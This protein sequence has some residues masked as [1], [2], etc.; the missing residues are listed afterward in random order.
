MGIRG[1]GPDAWL[2]RWR[3]GDCPVHGVGCVAPDES[4]GEYTLAACAKE[5]CGLVMALWPGKDEHHAKPGWVAGP[6]EIHAVLAKAG[7][8]EAEGPR[9]GR[10]AADARVSWPLETD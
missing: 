3:A 7:Q 6:E 10:W 8:I 5:E 2:A 4:D 1:Q 9:P